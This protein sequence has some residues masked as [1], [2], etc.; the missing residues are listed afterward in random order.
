[1]LKKTKYSFFHKPS[2]KHDIPL[3]LPKLTISNHVIER[4]EFIKF[5]G[6]LL[7]E[8]LNWKEH[9]KCTEN[10]IAKNLGLLYKARPFLE[11]NALLA[12][13]YSYIQTYINY[14]NISRQY[15]QD[16]PLKN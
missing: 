9:I 11:R 3:M 8:N 12:L 7:D 6:V 2:T 15:L 14:A 1:M 5:L 10:K 16:K 4:Q 13:C